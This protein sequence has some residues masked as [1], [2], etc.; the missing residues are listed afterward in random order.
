ME[1]F[2]IKAIL[3]A[4]EAKSLSRA[5]E[6]LS[7]SPS[8]FSHLLA[9]V[10]KE[11]GIKIFIRSS[12][13]VELNE[14]GQAL[15]PQFIELVECEKKI[16]ESADELSKK[17][18]KILRIGTYSSISRNFLSPIINDF[19]KLH[20]D[21]KISIS[22]AADVVKR[23]KNG[24]ADIVFADESGFFDE[25]RDFIPVINDR[26]YVVA[27]N[28][29]FSNTDVITKDEL[30]EHEYIITNEESLQNYFDFSKFKSTMIF[31]SDDSTAITNMV[32]NGFGVTVMPE[33]FFKD[34]PNGLEII[35][36]EP[37]VYRVIGYAFDEKN[38]SQALALFLE[39]IRGKISDMNK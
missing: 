27:P 18:N 20:P 10:E 16:L 34:I 36:L 21:I 1:I 14:N 5:A 26:C 6:S 30:Y 32:L 31:D 25:S 11:L 23:I 12:K 4:V 19:K 8:A 7:Y 3:A 9:S 37:K 17:E 29:Y 13:G 2:K 33:L 28:G 39:Y 24:K 35:P 22:V 38:E 15:L